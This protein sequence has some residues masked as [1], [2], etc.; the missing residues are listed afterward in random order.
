MEKEGDCII[1]SLLGGRYLI[2]KEIGRGGVGVVYLARD[3]QLLSKPVV[4]KI[5]LKGNNEN[6]WFAK[7]FLQE[8]EALARI[9]HPGVIGVL[10][11][12]Q[13]P[14]DKPYLVMQFVEGVN[15]RSI[16]RTGQMSF[17][18]TANIMRQIGQALSAAH[19]KGI[20]HRDLKPENIMVQSLAGGEEHVKLIDFGIAT[21][22]DSQV[23]PGEQTSTPAGTMAYMAPERLMG[24][25]SAASDIY[26]LGVMA[27]EMLTGDIPFDAV[28]A[29]RLYEMQRGGLK[30]KPKDLRPDISGAA[31]GIILNALSFSPEHRHSNPR[32]FGDMLARALSRVSEDQQSLQKTTAITG[33]RLNSGSP[34]RVAIGPGEAT[35]T[36]R[37]LQIVL[38]Y[39]RNTEPDDYLLKL[40]E[41]KFNAQGHSMFIDRHL[42]IG[43]E[44]AREIER[45]VRGAD[46]VVPLL[47]ALSVTSEMLAYEI[48]IAS[49][50]AQEHGKPRLLPIRVN[51]EGPLPESMAALLNP[52]QYALWRGPEDDERLVEEMFASMKPAPPG[53]AAKARRL[54]A[55]GGAVPLDS[56]FYI[57]RPTDEE[58]C[59]AIARCDSIVLVKGARQMGKTSLLARGLQQAR[60]A[61]SKIALTDL[62]T[63]NAV[64]LQ[65]VD[66][67]FMTLAES[68]TDQLDLDVSPKQIWNS[69]RGASLNFN[70]YMRKAVLPNLESPLVWGLDEVDRLFACDF[71]SEVFGL[72]RSWHNARS[73]DPTGPWQRLTLAIAYATEAHL[74]IT[75]IN[76]SPF[77]VGTRLGLQDFTVEQVSELNQ[78]YGS[79]LHNGSEISRF[80]RLV[81]GH[82]YLVRRS[83]QELASKK[84][85]IDLFEETADRD[86][87][88]LGDHLRR[89]MVLLAQDHLSC[90]AVRAV[91]R[92][93]GCPAT[94]SF[95][96]LRSAGILSGDSSKDARPRCHL[97]ETYLARHLA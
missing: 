74:F 12:G 54:E 82:P 3:K 42:T 95:Y 14:D 71:A 66:T 46:V 94:E 11:A 37:P 76:Q 93:E 62:Q 56:E 97:Y 77:N 78:R 70:R 28:S 50:S 31:Q 29:V 88:P 6:P 24:E 96:R 83:L 33:P 4:V 65:S 1:G 32:E 63:L 21:I 39:K 58:F 7:K 10:D 44:W 60:E 2:E 40:L 38:L 13:L 45:Q 86:E 53:L 22:K 75:D 72:F 19:D 9:D 43:V 15:L 69:E 79:P 92:G 90:D 73:L 85:G 87:G 8:I 17:A 23:S 64:H 18:R 61:G 89:I 51:Y 68:L 52:I 27:Y 25:V 47:S 67:L 55:V 81:G 30:I 59:S 35:T 41:S 26:A 36:L 57:V 91:L 48:Q 80:Y 34:G 84:T 49:E 20:Y 16:L 5:L